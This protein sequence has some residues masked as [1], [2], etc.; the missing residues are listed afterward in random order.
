MEPR[1]APGSELQ[2]AI[3]SEA[4]FVVNEEQR[5]VAWSH[6]AARLFGY[7][8]QAA[9][10]G[11]CYELV[12]ACDEMGH[13]FCSADCPVIA[14]AA[15]GRATPPLRLR[16]PTP[17]QESLS[18]EVSTIL[19]FSGQHVGSVVHICRPA[20]S[21]RAARTEEKSPP[22]RLTR[23]ER[24]VLGCLCNGTVASDGIAAE[25]GISPITVRNEIQHL[26]E[27]LAVHSRAEA[28]ALAYR[29]GLLP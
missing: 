10:G 18:L 14:A 4:V 5:I 29:E 9:V 7:D 3:S 6:E 24:Q 16:A 23:R 25:L 28:V 20:G 11:L 1:D 2:D 17:N 27:K 22:F 19:F 26:L 21:V 15:R 13:R 8:S 12:G